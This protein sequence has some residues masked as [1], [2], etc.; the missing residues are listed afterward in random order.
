[1]LPEMPL[2]PNVLPLP[3]L[4]E[5]RGEVTEARTMRQKVERWWEANL[6]KYAPAPSDDPDAYGDALNTNRDFTLVERKKADLF[7][8]RPDLSILASPL[9]EGHEDLLETHET[10]LNEKLGL[11]GVDALA[12]VHTVLFDVLCPSGMGWS[13]MGYESTTVPT[14]M[15]I[16]GP[17]T[18]MPGAVLGL[19]SVPGPMQTVMAPV[20]IYEDCFWKPFSP[21]QGLIPKSART[22][23]SDSWPWIGMEFEIETR[24]AKRRGWVPAEFTGS[25]SATDMHFDHGLSP[26]VATDVVRGVLIYYKSAL[27]RE[28]RPHPLHQTQLILI[29]GQDTPAEHKDSPYQTIDAQGRLTPDS[30]IGY[31]IHPMTIRTLTDAPYIPSDCT[32]SRPI[33]NE[34]NR[35]REQMVEQRDANV[36]RWMYNVDSLPP[37]ALAKIVRSP[38]GGFI[39]VPG[40]AFVGDGAIKELP[41]GTYPR[42]NFQF[43][44][45]LDNDLA[46]THA[47]D[48]EQSGA[49]QRGEQSATESQIKQNNVNARLGIERVNVL[50]WYLRGATKY[51]QIMQRLL[52]VEDAAKIVGQQKAQLWDTWRKTIPASLAFTALPDSAQRT[53]L[54]VNR[55]QALDQYSYWA[56]DPGVNR[57]EL[58]KWTAQRTGLPMKVVNTKP[59]PEKKPDPPTMSLAIKTEDLNPLSPA[60]GNV[61]QILTQ[62]GIKGLAPPQVDPVTAHLLQT[63]VPNTADPQTAHGGMMPKAEPLSK[64]QADQT[65]GLHGSGAMLQ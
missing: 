50:N 38:I 40:D 18:K 6:K 16:P 37:D 55:K 35:F 61:Y 63:Q 42:E 58:L 65:G 46:R 62:Q 56:N 48:A 29:D 14:P 24:I 32:I 47:I 39:G 44:D 51:S 64:H 3:N 11:D 2:R 15:Q 25:S 57:I 5:W 17:A 26:Q 21:K 34:L 30:L 4:E 45:Y 7:Y 13:V 1:M 36:M 43:N 10:I 53:D 59:P 31:P 12:L 33:I 60:Y 19:Q 28:D 20:P 9:L 23:R 22:V 54:A 52:P 27:Y 8:Q 49:G 41:H